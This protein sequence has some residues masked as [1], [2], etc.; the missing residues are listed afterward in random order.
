MLCPLQCE[1]LPSDGGVAV[2]RCCFPT[3]EGSEVKLRTLP[4]IHQ[5][6]QHGSPNPLANWWGV[7]LSRMGDPLGWEKRLRQDSSPVLGQHDHAGGHRRPSALQSA[8][9][10]HPLPPQT[11]ECQTLMD[12]PL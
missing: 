10:V 7:H 5:L 1:P 12:I 8:E 4:I 2:V 6:E 9:G 3:A 11:G